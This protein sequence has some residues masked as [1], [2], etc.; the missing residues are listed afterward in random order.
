MDIELRDTISIGTLAKG[1]GLGQNRLFAFLRKRKVLMHNNLPYQ[2]YIDDGHFK[3]IPQ[4]WSTP[5]GIVHT[6]WKTVA[7]PKGA[8]FINKLIDKELGLF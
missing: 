3:L 6:Y 5:D 7:T 1:A 8:D 2:D 4:R